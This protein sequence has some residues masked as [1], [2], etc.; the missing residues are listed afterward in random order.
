MG[1]VNPV[2]TSF[3]AGELTPRLVARIEF[4]KYDNAVALAEN[5][6]VMPE[7]GLTR[8]PGSR[9]IA[10]VEDSAE[11]TVLLPF[12]FSADQTYIL[13]LGNLV[14]RFYRNQGLIF[15]GTPVE[16]VTPWSGAELYELRIAQS[17]DTMWIVHPNHQPRKL[18]RSSHIAWTLS[19][20]APTANPFTGAGDFPGAV[21]FFEERILFAGTDNQP[22]T[23]WASK[24][25][26]FEDMTQG[27]GND[28]DAFEFT[29]ATD[30]VNRIR[31][32][33]P[34]RNLIM[35]T[36]GGEFVIDSVGSF[37]TPSDFSVRRHTALGSADLAPLRI[38]HQVV[39]VQRAGRKLYELV[40]QFA[41]DSMVATNLMRLAEHI[42]EGGVIQMAYAEEPDS[43]VWAFRSD[44][45]VPTMTYRR[46]EEIVAWD[47]Q[48]LGGSFGTGHAV[49]ESVATNQGQDGAGQVFSSADRD[50]VWLVVKRT[51]DGA[52]VRYVEMVERAFVGPRVQEYANRAAWKT[53]M[54]A[55][56]PD[57]F[58]VD[59]GLTYDGAATSSMS[60]LDHLEGE[61]VDIWAD[62][63]V[64]PTQVVIGGQ[65]NFATDTGDPAT[66]TKA[67]VGLSAPWRF[68]SLKLPFGG[69]A[70]TALVKTKRAHQVG[71][72][73]E[74]TGAF[75]IGMNPNKMK[76]AEFRVVED[77]IDQGPAMFTGES[78]ETLGESTFGTDPRIYM[79]GTSAAPFTILAMAPEMETH[80][81]K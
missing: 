61:T 15:D 51:I 37:L 34:G 72:V 53:A 46:E 80:D 70:G 9:F 43:I 59:S 63:A 58:Y 71:L 76:D 16:V 7:G 73:L 39:F 2:Q 18:T 24:S 6:Q 56:Q 31:W 79:N 28:D 13:E 69:R 36:I 52:T 57:A 66:V 21:C 20:Y 4:G 19:L 11:T 62:G 33:S 17:A 23:I 44:G 12:S 32:L 68:A 8:R 74:T 35:G 14:M 75:K 25:G 60:G 29:I 27:V 45:V 5:L 64:L 78:I 65:I 42:T 38:G 77:E 47:R 3:N 54:L 26:D 67:Q 40:L 30:Q 50:E 49:V 81:V 22:Q 1:R 55:A 10:E 48:I 41:D